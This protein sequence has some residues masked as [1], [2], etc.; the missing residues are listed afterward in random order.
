MISKKSVISGLTFASLILVGLYFFKNSE[1][2]SRIK[3]DLS[4]Q[5][6][7]S[8]TDSLVKDKTKLIEVK[9]L[10]FNGEE[11]SISIR[12]LDVMAND[13]VEIFKELKEMKFPIYTLSCYAPKTTVNKKKISLHAYAAAI[14]VNYLINPYYD[15]VEGKMIPN[16]KKDRLEDIKIITKELKA[17]KIPKNEIKAILKT[18]IQLEESDDRFLNRGIIRKGMIT[19]EIVKI[20]KKHGFNIWGGK[21]R[22]PID[23][24]HFQIPRPLAKQLLNANL[25]TRKKIWQT[26]KEKCQ[27]G[28]TLSDES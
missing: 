17:I 3:S 2:K 12:V 25:E 7:V 22:R 10:S 21:W 14:D 5:Y 1:N 8:E 11:K 24:M 27:L 23:Y 18:V 28:E 6:V 16:R 26:H 13:V 9:C 20:F 15:V 4:S 19:L